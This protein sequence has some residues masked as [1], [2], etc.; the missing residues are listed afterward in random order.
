MRSVFLHRRFRY[1]IIVIIFLRE[2]ELGKN[3]IMNDRDCD[4]FQHFHRKCI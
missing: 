1:K 4:E 3:K 2:S